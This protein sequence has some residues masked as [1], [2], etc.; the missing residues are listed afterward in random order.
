MSGLG[1]KSGPISGSDEGN[2]SETRRKRS[3][4]EKQR[5]VETSFKPGASVKAV[6]EARERHPT[7]L[8]KWRRLYERN[9][10][11]KSGRCCLCA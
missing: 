11:E 5:I 1:Q 6:A 10:E 4:S 9:A 8:Y 7:Q 3:A 2:A